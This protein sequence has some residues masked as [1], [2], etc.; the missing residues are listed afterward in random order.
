MPRTSLLQ[1]RKEIIKNLDNVDYANMYFANFS[2]KFRAFDD[3]MRK[4]LVS[5]HRVYRDKVKAI[6]IKKISPIL[7]KRKVNDAK[8]KEVF[9]LLNRCVKKCYGQDIFN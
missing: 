1:I 4:K 3:E 8:D 5:I 9:L 6:F 7:K 2:T